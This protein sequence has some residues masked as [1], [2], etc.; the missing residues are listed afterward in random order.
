MTGKN[1]LIVEDSDVDYD[2]MKWIF[3]EIE[4]DVNPKRFVN[5]DLSLN[6]LRTA[7]VLPSII[8]LDLNLPGTSGQQALYII[9]QDERLKSVP[10]IIN[11]TSNHQRDINE[12]FKNGAN[13]YLIKKADLDLYT[14]EIEELINY[15]FDVNQLPVN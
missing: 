9:K 12:C 8:L 1:I 10:V 4:V 14:K 11:S 5:A 6:Y 3:E 7:E 13:S 15:W 2:V